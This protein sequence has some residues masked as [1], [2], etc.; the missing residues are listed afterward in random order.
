M[1]S[2]TLKWNLRRRRFPH[3]HGEIV[4]STDQALGFTTGRSLVSLQR[5]RLGLRGA[6]RLFPGVIVRSRAQRI[7][8]G[9]GQRIHPVR[10]AFELTHDFPVRGV[11]H[12]DRR[13]PRRRVNQPLAAPFDGGDGFRVRRHGEQAHASHGVPH[14]H[15]SVRARRAKPHDGI[16]RVRRFP[17]ERGDV[18][19]VSLERSASRLASGRIPQTNRTVHAT[20]RQE[21]VIRAPRDAQHPIRVPLEREFRRLRV[22]VPQTNRRIAAPARQIFP[23]A[24][25]RHAQHRLGVSSDRRRAS[26]HRAH[27]KHALRLIHNLQHLFHGYLTLRDRRRQVPR[28]LLAVDVKRVRQRRPF[29]VLIRRQRPEKLSQQRLQLLHPHVR[30]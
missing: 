14:A 21:D 25:K 10:V 3:E 27:S 17:R 28:H 23:V 16:R 29:I 6:L 2:Q 1:A 11:P 20:A 12:E 18:L 8:C 30:G 19:L 9:E 22:Q 7:L 15:R 13:V 5:L 4:A 26:S 24:R